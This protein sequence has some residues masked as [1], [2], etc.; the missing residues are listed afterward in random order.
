MATYE[1]VYHPYERNRDDHDEYGIDCMYSINI[2]RRV[3][4]SFLNNKIPIIERFHK[5]I[6]VKQYI[7][8]GEECPICYEGIYNNPYLT[9]CGHSFHKECFCKYFN[10]STNSNFLCTTCP[11]CRKMLMDIDYLYCKKFCY[12]GNINGLNMHHENINFLDRLDDYETNIRLRYPESCKNFHLS[13]HSLGVNK[14]CIMCLNYRKD[15][16]H[17]IPDELLDFEDENLDE[18]G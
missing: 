15:G 16:S 13:K 8:P 7:Y 1:G 9:D 5:N 10:N 6:K 18:F 3:F 14:T 11:M 2:G 17:E 12:P 4:T